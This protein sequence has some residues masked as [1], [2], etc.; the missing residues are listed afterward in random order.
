MTTAAP[1]TQRASSAGCVSVR[2]DEGAAH[3]VGDD[4]HADGE[5]DEQARAVEVVAGRSVG[6]SPVTTR[7]S[8]HLVCRTP[9]RFG[10][11]EPDRVAVVEVERL[12]VEVEGQQRVGVVEPGARVSSW[13]R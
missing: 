10:P 12:A 1:T 13:P 8:T 6:R 7:R 9:G 2:V 3:A 4:R 11:I 5:P